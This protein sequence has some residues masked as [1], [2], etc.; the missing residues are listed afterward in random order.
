MRTVA[1]GS[2]PA[3]APVDVL[4]RP[5]P[6]A[7]TKSK[8]QNF[9]ATTAAE[10]KYELKP[11]LGPSVLKL[12]SPQSFL[13]AL[14]EWEGY[15]TSIGDQTFTARLIDKTAKS[16]I[17]EETAEFLLDDV[18]DSDRRLLR[19]GSIFRWVI[20]YL[21]DA[22]GSKRRVSEIVFRRLPAWTRHDL[23]SA[24]ARATEITKGLA[25]EE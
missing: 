21:K 23:L 20:G 18:S 22:G 9:A 6:T 17:E 19:E 3:G 16:H 4:P 7:E 25:W 24:R 10:Q 15:V 14:Q 12:R 2:R 13:H 1:T 8:E 5:A 11:N